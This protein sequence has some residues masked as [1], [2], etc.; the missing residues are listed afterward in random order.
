MRS[1]IA[2]LHQAGVRFSRDGCAMLAQ[3][4]A[5]N[6]LFAL[7]PLVLLTIAALGFIYGD[8]AAQM[9]AFALIKDLSPTLQSIITT[10]IQSAVAHR[11]LSGTL[12]IVSLVWSGKNLFLTLSYALNRALGVA[13]DRPFVKE[14]VL[15]IVMLPAV[16]V[17]MLVATA[18]PL[19]LSF[20]IRS[21]VQHWLRG[22]PESAGYATAILLVFVVCAVLY[23]VLPNTH[24]RWRF[25]LSASLFTALGWAA[26]QIGFAIYTT[27]TNFLVAYGAVSGILALL[28]WFYL[29]GTVFLYGA[30][31][32]A[33]WHRRSQQAQAEDHHG[34]P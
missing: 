27:H 31:L 23:R 14:I 16:G 2:T 4:I 3:A 13:Q 5:F 1:L 28:F 26:L 7:F 18:M 29:L 15:S 9:Q 19:T 21:H 12:G 11:G 24:V 32:C 8:A 34:R 20:L 33:E 22:A 10:N 17:I 30:E 6:A 25:A